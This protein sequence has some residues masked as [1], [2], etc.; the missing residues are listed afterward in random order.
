[1]FR[2]LNR[3][4]AHLRALEGVRRHFEGRDVRSCSR[5]TLHQY[6]L[7]E[8]RVQGSGGPL[9]T[10]TAHVSTA[11]GNSTPCPRPETLDPRP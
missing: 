7:K 8:F 5:H 10:A 3:D 1:M 4:S 9:G 6:R 2:A 11:S